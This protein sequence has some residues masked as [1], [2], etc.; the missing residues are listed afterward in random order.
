MQHLICTQQHENPT[1]S[2]M[3]FSVVQVT[4]VQHHVKIHLLHSMEKTNIHNM[5]YLQGGLNR[6]FGALVYFSKL[7]FC[8]N[9]S[10]IGRSFPPRPQ[11]SC[12]ANP[13]VLPAGLSIGIGWL[14]PTIQQ[15]QKN[16]YFF[17]KQMSVV[18]YTQRA[19]REVRGESS[20]IKGQLISKCLFDV[21]N[22]PK[23]QMK[24]IQLDVPYQ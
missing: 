2:N 6:I 19:S 9:D 7:S 11:K 17:S 12:F 15:E 18:Q 10:P 20:S 4:Y 24:T 8:Q 21:F 22:S 23:K 1:T 5:Y 13:S 16:A 3:Q 14:D